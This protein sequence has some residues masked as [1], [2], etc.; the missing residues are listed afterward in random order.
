[1]R[2]PAS[3]PSPSPRNTIS[4]Y[5]SALASPSALAARSNS[6]HAVGPRSPRHKQ[7]ERA[8][9]TSPQ[10]S[11]HDLARRREERKAELDAVRAQRRSG[12]RRADRVYALCSRVCIASRTRE[13]IPPALTRHTRVVWSPQSER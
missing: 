11:A 9:L 4:F 7:L 2:L 3:R 10:A 13:R 5:P 8:L 1:M 6:Q 12:A